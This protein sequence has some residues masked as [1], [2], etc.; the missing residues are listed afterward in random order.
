MRAVLSL[1]ILLL[2]LSV[3]AAQQHN[4][5]WQVFRS[6]AD[7][8]SVEMPGAPKANSRDL[9]SGA[10][11]K[12]FVVEVGVEAYLASVIQLPPGGVPANPDE[13]YFTILMK[14]YCDGSGT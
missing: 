6:E 5:N 10:S 12:F 7:G 14:A 11:Q 4:D 13:A 1:A 8:F 9:G 3:V 2:A